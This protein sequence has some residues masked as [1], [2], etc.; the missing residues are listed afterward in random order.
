MTWTIE[1]KEELVLALREAAEVEQTLMCVYLYAA[2]SMRKNPG[3]GLRPSQ[4]EAVRRWASNVYLIARQ[5]M[6]HLAFVNGMLCAI[7]DRPWFYRE[8]IPKEGLLSRFF[9]SLSL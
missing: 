2:L 8:N 9:T 6:E 3:P 4:L 7:G 1:T 5:E